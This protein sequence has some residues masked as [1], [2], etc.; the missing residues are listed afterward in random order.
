MAFMRHT[1]RL[2]LSALAAL[3]LLAGTLSVASAVPATATGTGPIL[4]SNSSTK[5]TAG[6]WGLQVLGAV[7]TF[8]T[9]LNQG[10]V[11]NLISGFATG[12]AATPDGGGY[13]VV[14]ADGASYAVG[15]AKYEGNTPTLTSGQYILNVAT[16]DGLN[17]YWDVGQDGGVFAFGSAVFYGSLPADGIVT[18]TVAGI[19]ATPDA[20]G[21]WVV[22]QNGT[23]YP[24]GDATEAVSTCAN[25]SNTVTAVGNSNFTWSGSSR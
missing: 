21:Y 9:A 16:G 6:L 19:A 2:I 25:G 1:Y 17:G 14:G 13:W 20:K 15:D 5:T 12:I 7:Q 10:G 3:L 18:S 24:F 22:L 11:E 8:G 4:A 23:V